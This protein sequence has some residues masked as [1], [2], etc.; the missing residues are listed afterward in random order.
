MFNTK[1]QPEDVRDI[2]SRYML[3][4]GLELIVD[5]EKSHG[6]WYVDARNGDRYI[7]FYTGVSSR[8]LGFNHPKLL[9]DDVIRRL[10]R[11]AVNKPANADAYSAPMAEFVETFFRVAV[12]SSMKH[13][14]FIEG[15]ALAVENAIKA[16]VDWKV[17]KNFRRGYTADRYP[18]G[19]G[20][21]IIHLKECFHGRSGYTVSMTDSP[22]PNK[23]KWFPKFDWPRI[24]TPKATFPLTGKN[25]EKTVALEKQACREIEEA[26]A[27]NPDDIAALVLEP[28]QG[29]G[30]DNHFRTEFFQELRRLADEHEFLLIFDEVQT[31]IGLT[32]KMWAYQHHGVEPDMIC[33]GKK[34]QVC[35]FLAGPRIDEV[36][37]NVFQVSSRINST[38]GGNLID[39]ARCQLFLEIIEEENLLENVRERGAEL[40][41]GLNELERE[42]DGAVHN[43]RG[44]GLFCALDLD[45]QKIDRRLLL[46]EIRTQGALILPCGHQSVRFRPAL[47]IDRETLAEGLKRFRAALVRVTG[48]AA[49]TRA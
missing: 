13:V 5:L 29:E 4:D 9:G 15:G 38:W 14:F 47:D 28:I 48:K 40:L 27:A 6:S 35:G 19:H 37:G 11:L 17:Q 18:D 39:M 45:P 25:L 21:R 1:I 31:G 23:T 33:F 46:E 34:T 3:V 22:D 43:V 12:P 30:G 42:L 10:G 7:D 16:A 49:P 20:K 8:P 2:L 24:T 32:G 41:A 44:K 36:E 26:L